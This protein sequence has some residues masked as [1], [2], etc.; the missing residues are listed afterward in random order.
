M[1]DSQGSWWSVEMNKNCL[2]AVSP[3]ALR[4][5]EPEGRGWWDEMSRTRVDCHCTRQKSPTFQPSEAKQSP[6][7]II[8]WEAS[9]F[10]QFDPPF[11]KGFE[12]Q[13]GPK[14]VGTSAINQIR[15]R[16]A[17]VTNSLLDNGMLLNIAM[18]ELQC[19]HNKK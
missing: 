19:D 15:R 13:Q 5:K 10:D 8:N 16:S 6:T 9:P 12:E 3:M 2:M 11:E 14:A 4:M 7:T 1:F 17:A 18:F